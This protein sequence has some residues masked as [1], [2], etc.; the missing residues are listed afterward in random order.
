MP[1]S[2]RGRVGPAPSI[3]IWVDADA[4]PREIREILFRAAERWRIPVIF[5]ANRPLRFK[6]SPHVQALLVPG[7]LDEADRAIA[8]EARAGELVVTADIP[9][10]A[11]VAAKGAFALDP[12]GTLHSAETVGERLSV[13]NWLDAWRGA[14]MQTPGPPAMKP[15]DRKAFADALDRFLSRRVDRCAPPAS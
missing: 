11:A 15:A 2:A 12:R 8:Q 1:I 10:A 6:K 14:G 5:V 4:C 7:G 13:R 3:R 9:L